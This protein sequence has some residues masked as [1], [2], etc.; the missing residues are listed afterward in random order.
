[1]TRNI[2]LVLSVTSLLTPALFTGTGKAADGQL[3]L[4]IEEGIVMVLEN[5]LDIV[6]ERISP[7]VEEALSRGYHP[8][9]KRRGYEKRKVP[10]T[11]RFSLL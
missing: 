6:I 11:G 1:M 2:I 9:S 4:S 5:N 8:R 10:L 7:K 3:E